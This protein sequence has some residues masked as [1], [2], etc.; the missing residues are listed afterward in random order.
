[1]TILVISIVHL[2]RA[3]RVLFIA[4]PVAGVAVGA[5]ALAGYALYEK[6]KNKSIES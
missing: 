3:L 6:S 1:M 5:A 2:A 4:N